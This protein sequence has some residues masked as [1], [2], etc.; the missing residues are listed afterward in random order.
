MVFQYRVIP[1]STNKT[2]IQNLETHR[3]ERKHMTRGIR[4][5]GSGRRERKY[6]KQGK[7]KRRIVGYQGGGEPVTSTGGG[8][9]FNPATSA[10]DDTR[11]LSLDAIRKLPI[12]LLSKWP[13]PTRP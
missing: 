3:A 9:G 6:K 12:A 2:K 7:K 1:Q 5:T 11:R 4:S 13:L 8:V 10:D